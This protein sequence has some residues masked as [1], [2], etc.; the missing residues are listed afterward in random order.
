MHSLL[1]S[2][3]QSKHINLFLPSFHSFIFINSLELISFSATNFCFL[4]RLF[5]QIGFTF[6]SVS[7]VCNFPC[8]CEFIS[9]FLSPIWQTEHEK[10]P[11]TISILLLCNV[12][13]NPSKL[14]S[15]SMICPWEV[16]LRSPNQGANP[17]IKIGSW[18][19]W[20]QSPKNHVLGPI[21]QITC[22]MIPE[23]HFLSAGIE[24]QNQKLF[25]LGSDAKF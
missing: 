20:S 2:T 1:I 6:M 15:F 10:L 17:S 7:F 9:P 24:P 13:L 5:G 12:F 18:E 23:Q 14:C 22:V 25:P 8:R 19:W 11:F 4:C 3:S 21:P 16:K